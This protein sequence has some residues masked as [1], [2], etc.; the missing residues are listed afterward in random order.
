MIL[1]GLPQDSDGVDE[2]GLAAEEGRRLQHIDHRRHRR[3]LVDAMDVGQ[4]RHANLALHFGEN[5]QSFIEAQAADRFSGAAVGLV[6]GGLE[7]VRNSQST[8]DFL[9]VRRDIDAQLF[10][11][12]RTGAGDQEKRLV[13]TSLESAELHLLLAC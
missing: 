7:N 4:Y 1:T 3:N 6:V 8:A 13:K 2:I 9:H 12:G 11:F 5:A 10:R